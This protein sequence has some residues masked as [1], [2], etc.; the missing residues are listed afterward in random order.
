M[1]KIEKITFPG[2][3]LGEENPMPDI[4]NIS[5]IHAGYELTSKITEE[6]NKTIVQLTTQHSPAMG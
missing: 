2:A 3:N 6:E 1:I 5:Y 4:K